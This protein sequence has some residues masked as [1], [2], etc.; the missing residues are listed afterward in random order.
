[1]G[2]FGSSIFDYQ[3]GLDIKKV[4]LNKKGQLKKQ[5]EPDRGLKFCSR[6]NT[7]IYRVF[8]NI[9]KGGYSYD[10][11]MLAMHNAAEIT[12]NFGR[13]GKTGKVVNSTLAAFFQSVHTRCR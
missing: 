7:E 12:T 5:L 2:G 3:Q 6:A 1:M 8:G 11:L 10:N 13:H 4:K 9:K